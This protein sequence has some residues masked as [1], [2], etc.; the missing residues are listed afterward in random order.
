[1]VKVITTTDELIQN[2]IEEKSDVGFV[3]TMGNLHDGHISLLETALKDLSTVYFSIFVNPKQFGPDEDF[4]RYPRTLK[5]DISLIESMM[6]QFPNSKV[7]VYAPKETKEVFPDT[8]S[9]TISVEGLSKILEG[10]IRPGHF[11]GVTTVVYRLFELVKPKK[12]YFGLKDYQQLMVIKQMVRDLA[13]PVDVVGLPIIR[14]QNGLAFSSRNQFLSP[15]ERIK[16]LTLSKTLEEVA[17]LI[18]KKRSNLAIAKS[19][20]EKSLQD[21]NW[22]YLEI[23]DAETLGE[24]LSR[25]SKLTLLGVYQLGS[26]RLLDNLQMEIE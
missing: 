21:K 25:S 12:A 20:I 26:T 18:N 3:P 1:M 7:I 11:D 14:E 9:H 19:R 17:A 15:D 22:N 2:R 13:L 24:D 6:H 5:D 23:R 4:K 8:F 10:E 16:S